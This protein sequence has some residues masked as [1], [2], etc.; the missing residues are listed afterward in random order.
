MAKKVSDL[1]GDQNAKT[2]VWGGLKG[3]RDAYEL[4]AGCSVH[5]TCNQD[6]KTIKRGQELAAPL[7]MH[8]IEVMSS[9]LA[10]GYKHLT[11]FGA[12]NG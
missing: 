6:N 10:Q 1:L 12:D 3:Y 11:S 7:A 9:L 5:V 8:G 2:A 4:S